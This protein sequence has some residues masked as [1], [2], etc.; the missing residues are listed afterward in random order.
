MKYRTFGRTGWKVSEIG[1]G[2]WQVGGAWGPLDDDASVRTLHYAWDKGINFVD[3]AQ[4]YGAG[5][6]EKVIGRALSEWTGDKIFVATKAQPTV[7]PDP[8]DDAPLFRGR[9]PEWHLRENVENSLRR[10]QVESIYLYQLHS[11]GPT[12]HR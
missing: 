9:F 6:S 8:G 4:L 10:L 1:L 2:G 12:G 3:T 7:W 5:H 11:W